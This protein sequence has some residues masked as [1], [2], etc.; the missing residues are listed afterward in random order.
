CSPADPPTPAA[1]AGVL[2]GDVIV[3]FNGTPVDDWEQFSEMIRD[4]LGGSATVVVQ[5]D[6]A[7]LTLPTVNTVVT[8]VPSR[9]DPGK[10]IEAGFFGV[11]PTMENERGGPIAVVDQMWT[12]TKQ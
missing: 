10:N 4:N 5:R 2:P 1:A 6:G 7:E 3:S 9:W 11:S 8:G 12:M